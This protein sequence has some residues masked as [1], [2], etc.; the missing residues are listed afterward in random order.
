M[1]ISL[2]ADHGGYEL[3][4]ALQLHLEQKGHAVLNLGTDST[5]PCDY[6]DYAERVALAVAREETERGI[7]VCGSGVGACIAANKVPGA[8]AAVCHDTFSAHQGV[9]DD[10]MNVLCL[11]A[12]VIGPQLAVEIVETWLGARF[13]KAER[14]QRRLSKVTQL[15]R[16][17][18]RDD[19]AAS[20]RTP[21]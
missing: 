4:R 9:E 14:H 2:G 17:Y 8:R 1:K 10:D 19:A 18:G 20:R 3:K 6:P 7:M 11:G 16:R 15:E 12:R 5:D 21:N 13:S